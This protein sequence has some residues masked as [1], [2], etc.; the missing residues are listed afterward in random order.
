MGRICSTDLKQLGLF[1][2]LREY[3]RVKTGKSNPAFRSL[4]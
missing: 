2:G 4:N 3:V 1:E